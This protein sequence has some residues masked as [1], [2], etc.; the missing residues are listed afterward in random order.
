MKLEDHV[1]KI[2]LKVEEAVKNTLDRCGI[3]ES[4]NAF[5]Q[6]AINGIEVGNVQQLIQ[7]IHAEKTKWS[8]CYNVIVD[9]YSF[10]LFN[11]LVCMKVLE[12]HGLYPEMITQRQQHSGKSYSH[13]MWLES[14]LEYKNDAF[15]GIGAFI[16]WQFNQLASE[17]DLFSTDIPLHMIPTSTFIKEIID[18]INLIDEDD[19][20]DEEIWKNGNILSQIYEIYNNSKKAALKESGD[21]VEYDKVHI[22]SQIYTPEW[23]VKFLVD[24]SLG[25][26]YLEMY[27]DSDI[28]NTH[29]IIGDFTE[30][31]RSVKPLDEIK[32]IDPCVG[33]GNFLLYCFDLFYDMYIDQIENYGADYS[34]RDIP[35]LIIE[36]N[37]HGIDLDERAVQLTKVGLFIKAKTKRNSIKLN[38]YNV[39]SAS[40]RLPDYSKIGILF[41]A[42]YFSKDFSELLRDVWSDLKQAH[43]FGSLLRIDEKFEIKKKELKKELGGPQITFDNYE[44]VSEFDLFATNFYDKLGEAVKNYATDDTRRFDAQATTEAMAF[45]KIVTEK[46]DIVA[47]NPPYTDSADM[48]EQLHD[49]I[50]ENY[51]SPMKFTGNLYVAFYKRNYEFINNNGFLAMIHPLT[52]MYLSTYKD[53]RIHILCNASIELFVDYGLSNL[54]GLTMVDPAFYVLRKKVDAN[55]ISS[56]I[57]L[58]QY[59]RTSEEKYKKQY[60]LDALDSIIEHTS[61][62]NVVYVN[63][64]E[65]KKIEDWPFIYNVS[66]ELRNNFAAGSVEKAGIKVAQGLATSSNER[67]VRHWWEVIDKKANPIREKWFTY[68]KGGPYCKWYGN[69]WAVVNWAN[70]GAEIKAVKDPKT[71]KQK[72]RPQNEQFYKKEGITYTGSG[73]KGTTFR[74]Q[75]RNAL[76]DVGGSCLFPTGN[77]KNLEYIMAIMNSRLSFYLIDC[78]NPTVNTQ[79]GDLKRVPFVKPEKEIETSVSEHA[80]KCIELKKQIDS[81]YILNGSIM[82]PLNINSTVTNA[83]LNFISD[84]ILKQSNILIYEMLMDQEINSIYGLSEDDI[85]RMTEKMGVCAA[86]I[87]V[88]SEAWK[89]YCNTQNAVDGCDGINVVTIDYTD[90]EIEEIKEKIQNVLFSK[91]NELEDFC[92][93]NGINPIT[94]WHL[95]TNEHVLPLVK[96][97]DLVFEWFVYAIRDIISGTDDGIISVNNTDTPITQIIEEYADSKGINSAQLLQMEEFLGKKIRDFMEKDFFVELMNYTNVFMYLPKTPF[98]WHLSSGVNRGF[99]ALVSIYKWNTDSLYKLKSCYI[100]KR[101]EQLEFRKTQIPENN[102][103]QTLEEKELIDNQLIEIDGFVEK[104]D[105]LIASGYNPTL[106]DGVGKNIAPLQEKKML[107]ADVLNANQLKKYLKAEW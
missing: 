56:F 58:D 13:Y 49:F 36:K 87:S 104:I 61:N 92:K 25:K 14:N 69:N 76:F 11:R 46:Y 53:M 39:V 66:D 106:D 70:D 3:T 20:V 81:N 45:L 57:S 40:F 42:Q 33:S 80:S 35:Q 83:L 1:E 50:D 63:Q 43:K 77:V 62:K 15:E 82:S 38:H 41:D 10:T 79:V 101:R 29:K 12:A 91:N 59:T 78:L 24:N 88:F 71:R 64:N 55:H 97:R 18:L 94:V 9:D 8:D 26:L 85:S 67:F 98:I 37:L 31:T 17:C 72:S 99:E 74:L 23:V 51:K 5:S 28:K 34:K 6:Q 75:E 90:K 68:S 93:L 16:S 19:Q 32:V 21:K 96:A 44:K 84:E 107:K 52:F 48:G 27:P 103:A 105:S 73:S 22:Q 86:S 47:S 4:E 102:T 60:C 100:H 95:V 54:F 30:S 65:F 2:R 89:A 7:S